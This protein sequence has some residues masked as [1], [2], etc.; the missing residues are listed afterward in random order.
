MGRSAHFTDQHFI[1]AAQAVIAEEGPG[2]LTI[3]KIAAR[4][5]ATTGSVYH[6]FDSLDVIAATARLE[7]AESFQRDFAET[8]RAQA[9]QNLY[10]VVEAGALHTPAWSRRHLVRARVLL[11]QEAFEPDPAP[12]PEDL[13]RRAQ[14]LERGLRALFLPLA[15]NFERGGRG[16]R[17][18]LLQFLLA[19]M[20]L[21]AVKPH[22]KNGQKPPA[23]VDAVIRKS[24]QAFEKELLR[25]S[26]K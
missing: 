25:E 20:P 7:A 23:F 15:Q 9:H 13:R 5:G 24:V 22:L 17:L 11:R 10:A 16:E 4:A 19:D 2:G 21:A 12:L 1:A 3:Q 6:R 14:K 8:L 26:R 18:Q